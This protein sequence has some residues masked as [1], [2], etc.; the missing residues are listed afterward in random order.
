MLKRDPDPL[1]KWTKTT[2]EQGDVLWFLVFL[3]RLESQT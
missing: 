1:H 2:A 3:D